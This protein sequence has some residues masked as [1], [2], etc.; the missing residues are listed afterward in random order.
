VEE[1]DRHLAMMAQI[2]ASAAL[3]LADG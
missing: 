3:L 2:R 1:A